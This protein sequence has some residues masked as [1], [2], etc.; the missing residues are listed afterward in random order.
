MARLD[1]DALL[2][3]CGPAVR[4]LNPNLF[5]THGLAPVPKP[6]PA[7]RNGIPSAPPC[8]TRFATRVLVRITSYR[9]QP[10]DPDNI[11]GKWMVDCLRYS[12]VIRNDR[13]EDIDY[14]IHQK[15]VSSRKEER[16]EIEVIPLD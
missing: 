10:C 1:L 6:Q 12:R 7:V 9:C 3:T 14:Q 13:K 2:T 8:E 5:P 4:R 15:K 11:V 16:T